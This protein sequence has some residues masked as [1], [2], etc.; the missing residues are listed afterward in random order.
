VDTRILGGNHKSIF[1]HDGQINL[2][3][4]FEFAS[5]S[6]LGFDVPVYYP[7]WLAPN[8]HGSGSLENLALIVRDKALRG[9]LPESDSEV[10]TYDISLLEVAG[11]EFKD[12]S[13]SEQI[14]M[15]I[16][17]KSAAFTISQR[18]PTF[19]R[20]HEW[21]VYW[22]LNDNRGGSSMKDSLLTSW[23]QLCEFLID[24]QVL[25]KLSSADGNLR[26]ELL[27]LAHISESK[28]SEKNIPFIGDT[29]LAMA[30]VRTHRPDVVERVAIVAVPYA[31]WEL[32]EPQLVTLD[33]I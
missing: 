5:W 19:N 10:V 7:L 8:P 25:S 12:A 26:I 29:V 23:S 32:A 16:T 15:T 20:S 22:S 17:T 24:G 2:H 9:R 30:I 27:M 1:D 31:C 11:F 13:S 14:T 6:W 33:I 21:K 18:L 3:R 4:R 28:S